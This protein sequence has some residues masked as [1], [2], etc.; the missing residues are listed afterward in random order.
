METRDFSEDG[1]GYKYF[2]RSIRPERLKKIENSV[3]TSDSI[4]YPRLTDPNFLVLNF[5]RE[6]ISDWNKKLPSKKLRVLDL[7]GRLQ[8]YRKLFGDRQK[9]YVGIDPVFEGLID[10]LGV[11]EHLPFAEKKFDVVIC[12][13]VLNYT[14]D[15]FLVIR[16]IYRVLKKGG[17]LYLSVPAIFP[18]YHNQRWRFMPDG[19]R[20]LLSQFSTVEI[21]PEGYSIAGLL[22]LI[23]LFFDTFIKTGYQIARIKSLIFLITNT[24]GMYL[25]RLSRGK[26]Q[27][28]TNYI[29]RACK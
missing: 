1:P 19:L 25:D 17:F 6:I 9:Q 3:L 23:N 16:E 12:T 10:T 27:L 22:R 14:T 8:P 29:C 13:Q 28:S 5:R 21:I 18:R 26:S 20:V 4:L 11:G 7:G 2:G 15:P 24:A